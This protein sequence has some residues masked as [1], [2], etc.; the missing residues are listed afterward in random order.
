MRTPA[1]AMD[2][3]LMAPSTSPIWRALL[4]PTAWAEVPMPTPLAMG[5]VMWKT[6]QTV[7]ASRLPAM[8]VRMT[9]APVRAAMPPSS[10]ATSMLMAVVTDLGS[11]V[12]YC[13][14]VRSMATASAKALPRLTRVPTE[15]PAMMAAAFSLSRSH[16]SYSG[17]A[18][19]MVAGSSR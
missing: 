14:R 1:T 13:S 7:S 4:V 2:R 8:P 12:T 15:M 16:F 18:R 17:M 19:L 5:S 6:L 10:A 11:R 3:P 9:M